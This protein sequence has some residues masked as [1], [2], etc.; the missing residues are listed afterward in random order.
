MK[1]LILIIF[2]YFL[3]KHMFETI[4]KILLTFV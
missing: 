1:T 3:L 4:D 2:Y